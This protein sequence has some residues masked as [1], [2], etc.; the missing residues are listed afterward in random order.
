[1]ERLKQTT[2]VQL[3]PFNKSFL[4]TIWKSGFSTDH[5]AWTKWNAPYFN[6]YRK[7]DDAESFGASPI[8]D[9]LMSEDCRCIVVDGQPVGMARNRDCDL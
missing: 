6:D 7:F 5:P 1:M 2:E 8:A 4:E 3:L 9:F